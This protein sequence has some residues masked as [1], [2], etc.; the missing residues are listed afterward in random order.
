MARIRQ[1]TVFSLGDSSALSTWSNVP[2]F[3]TETLL[4]KGVQVNR[5]DLA[6][7]LLA[8]ALNRAL[9]L[10]LRLFH[11]KSTFDY[12]RSIVHYWDVRRR[13]AK[14]ERRFPDSDV[15]IFL[16]FSFSSAGLSDKPVVLF[17]DWTYDHCITH[18]RER[19]P[20]RFEQGSVAREDFQIESA[21][22][23]FVLFPRVAEH[24]R[25][26]YHNPNI[27]YLGNVV[28]ALIP[29]DSA[30]VLRTKCSSS[31]LLFIG[32]KKY[33]E[34][35]RR[36]IAA[37][38]LLKPSFPALTLTLIGLSRQDFRS[39]PAGVECHGYLDK[40]RDDQRN[41][42]YE[43]MRNARVIVNTTPKWGAFSAMIEAMQFFTPVIVTPYDEFVR[44]FGRDIPFGMYC[45]DEH[46]STLATLI[47][48]M[49]TSARYARLCTEAHAAVQAFS[50]PAYIDR[51]LN[52]VEKP[53][54]RRAPLLRA[55]D[56]QEAGR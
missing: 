38:E 28:N 55:G 6:P 9:V 42:Y 23:V 44:T 22:H 25:A 39:L 8:K 53:S 35:A 4:H 51:V 20:D 15:N 56:A 37:Y 48:Q 54:P 11:S 47:E 2:Y 43:L 12:T 49:L 14:A 3:F 34:G 36:L 24:M 30:A 1:A 46:P 32:G 17:A 18:F 45:E 5:V 50:W 13:I 41:T 52:I 31:N 10:C 26:R 33:I 40:G 27:H 16:T 7:R 19:S 21:D 29:V